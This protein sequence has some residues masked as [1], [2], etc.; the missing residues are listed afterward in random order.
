[1]WLHFYKCIL[2][3]YRITKSISINLCLVLYRF[4][5]FGYFFMLRWLQIRNKIPRK[6]FDLLNCFLLIKVWLMTFTK[7]FNGGYGLIWLSSLLESFSQMENTKAAFVHCTL[8]HH[9]D[10]IHLSK[11]SEYNVQRKVII[12]KQI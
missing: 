10:I 9:L 3:A 8:S 11:H 12:F 7:S 1:M 4:N 5:F 6:L 2:C